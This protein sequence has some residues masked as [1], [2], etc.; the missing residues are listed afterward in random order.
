MYQGRTR[1]GKQR[2]VGVAPEADLTASKLVFNKVSEALGM[3]NGIATT[4]EDGGAWGK[5]H[6]ARR[7]HGWNS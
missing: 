1:G 2:L 4:S 6:C 7:G 3:N 5:A